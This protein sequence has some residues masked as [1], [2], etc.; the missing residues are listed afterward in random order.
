MSDARPTTDKTSGP[1]VLLVDEDFIA[2]TEDECA[3][4]IALGLEDPCFG[5]WQLAD[6]LGEHREDGR[7]ESE[8]HAEMRNRNERKSLIHQRSCR[9]IIRPRILVSRAMAGS[10]ALLCQLTVDGQEG[11]CF[12]LTS[13]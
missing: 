7:I 5:G 8:V 1:Y 11:L 4:T 6:S 3:E 12:Q 2:V 9:L 13:Q 10:R